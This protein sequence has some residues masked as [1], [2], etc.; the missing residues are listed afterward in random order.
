MTE[1]NWLIFPIILIMT[2]IFRRDNWSIFR[3]VSVCVRFETILILAFT[4]CLHLLLQRAF[5]F[6]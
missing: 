3:R 2:V 1:C 5:A 4:V 6:G